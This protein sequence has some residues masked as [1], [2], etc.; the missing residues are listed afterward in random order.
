MTGYP[1][2]LDGQ[3]NPSRVQALMPM[4]LFMH[5]G[6]QDGGWLRQMQEQADHLRRDGFKIRFT[7]EKDQV[8]RLRAQEI[9]LSPRLFDQIESCGR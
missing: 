6:D 1:G 2:L 9:N 5:V 7:I 8:H 3:S 4:C